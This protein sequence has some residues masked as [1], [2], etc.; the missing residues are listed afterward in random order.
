MD[1]YFLLIKELNVDGWHMAFTPHRLR[2]LGAFLFVASPSPRALGRPSLGGGM[3]LP[4]DLKD[5]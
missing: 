2:D 3:G 1:G 5:V 4:G